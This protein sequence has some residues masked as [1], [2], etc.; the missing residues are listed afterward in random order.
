MKKKS[1]KSLQLNKKSI[2]NLESATLNGGT[3][4]TLSCASRKCDTWEECSPCHAP[5][6]T[7]IPTVC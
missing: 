4:R 1:V 5:M 6:P 7:G 2:S 3:W